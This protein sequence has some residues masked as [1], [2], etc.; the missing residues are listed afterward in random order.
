[1]QLDNECVRV[2]NHKPTSLEPWLLDPQISLGEIATSHG[3]RIRKPQLMDMIKLPVNTK[4]GS[5]Q[6]KLHAST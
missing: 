4:K 3:L 6:G 2:R 1:M 5:D